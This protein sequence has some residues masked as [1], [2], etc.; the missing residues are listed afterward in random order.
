MRIATN[1]QPAGLEQMRIQKNG[2]LAT[3]I[4][5]QLAA[6]LRQQVVLHVKHSRRDSVELKEV[7]R[8]DCVPA[9]GEGFVIK[10]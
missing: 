1:E 3:S 9:T 4:P 7:E 5:R 8:M 10:I 6:N 2:M